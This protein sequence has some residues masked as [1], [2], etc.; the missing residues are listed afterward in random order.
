MGQMKSAHYDSI[1]LISS[2]FPLCNGSWS[3]LCLAALPAGDR[4]VLIKNCYKQNTGV[5]KLQ[6]EQ[7]NELL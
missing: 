7:Y 5:T 2:F 4:A 6:V 3:L 1:G